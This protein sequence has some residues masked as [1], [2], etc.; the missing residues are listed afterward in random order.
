MMKFMSEDLVFNFEVNRDRSISGTDRG[1]ADPCDGCGFCIEKVDVGIS[2]I[3]YVGCGTGVEVPEIF[4]FCDCP[5]AIYV[6]SFRLVLTSS[7]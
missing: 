1:T 2:V 6:T 7:A 4:G 5:P 3:G